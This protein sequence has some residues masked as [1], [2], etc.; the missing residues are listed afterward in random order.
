MNLAPIYEVLVA[1]LT[2]CQKND[3]VCQ[4]ESVQ[5]HD[6][7]CN[8]YVFWGKV[9]VV[10]KREVCFFKTFGTLCTYSTVGR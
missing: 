8:R 2:I 1:H 3:E 9:F 4:T 10:T 5:K 7:V 6:I